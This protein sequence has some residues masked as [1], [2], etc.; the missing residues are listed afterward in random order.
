MSI[1]MKRFACHITAHRP[2]E[3]ML[4]L[5]NEYK[6]SA[7]DVESIA[8]TGNQ[9]MATTNNIP[10]PPDVLLAQYSIPFS[11]ALSL[12]RN[13]IDPDSFDDNVHRDAQILAMAKRVKMIAAPGQSREDLRSTV[14]VTEGQTNVSLASS[15]FPAPPPPPPRCRGHARKIHAADQAFPA[16]RHGTDVR[17]AAKS[18]KREDAG[19]DFGLTERLACQAEREPPP[20]PSLRSGGPPP[21]SRRR[22]G[23]PPDW[24]R[25]PLSRFAGPPPRKRENRAQ[26]WV[27]I[28]EAVAV[29]H[30]HLHDGVLVQHVAVL[31]E[32]VEAQDVGDAGIDLVIGQR[33]G[34]DPTAWPGARNR[35]PWWHKANRSRPSA[36]AGLRRFERADAAEEARTRAALALLAVAGG[37]FGRVDRSALRGRAGAG[38]QA[39][40][41]GADGD[42]PGGGVLFADGLAEFGRV[43]GGGGAGRGGE[44][45]AAANSGGGEDAA[46]SPRPPAMRNGFTHRHG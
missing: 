12:Y 37:A 32:A 25:A 27:E 35:T 33:F 9:R 21:R 38:G 8:I 46:P 1:M 29:G 14:A 40:A 5:K 43:G 4:D 23:A 26:T 45:A 36:P 34:P 31:D 39:L 18:R 13:P 3:A 20:P 17:T 22:G 24:T 30:L 10:A 16:R 44:A 6:F 11:V 7:A 15:A 41:V 42:V 19:L 2:V 28:D